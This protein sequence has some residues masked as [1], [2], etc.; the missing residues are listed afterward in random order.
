MDLTYEKKKA[1][2]LEGEGDNNSSWGGGSNSTQGLRKENRE[3]GYLR[4]NRDYLGYGYIETSSNFQKSPG[5][6][7]RLALETCVKIHKE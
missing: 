5:D 1:V 3:I 6:V 2:E 7:R 4:K